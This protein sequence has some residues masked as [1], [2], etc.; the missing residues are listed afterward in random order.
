MYKRKKEK[1]IYI[2]ILS[3]VSSGS[4]ADRL[5]AFERY[6]SAGQGATHAAV[7]SLVGMVQATSYRPGIDRTQ[8]VG[9]LTGCHA[10]YIAVYR[11]TVRLLP[12]LYPCRAK[13]APIRN[14][15]SKT[16][17]E[18]GSAVAP[19][20][21]HCRACHG[22]APETGTAQPMLSMSVLHN[23]LT[24]ILCIIPACN[25]LTYMIS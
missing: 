19:L 16:V 4:L 10:C 20:I 1:E 18:H 23:K 5:T 11:L 24:Y 15:R 6:G 9:R 13:Y 14:E 2:Y 17:C 22:I 21:S 7:H 12:L 3:P 8:T 25:K